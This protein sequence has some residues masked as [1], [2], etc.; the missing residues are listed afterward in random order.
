MA[1]IY[2]HIPFCRKAC[3]YCNFHFSTS[4]HRK[5]AL[6]KALETE[7]SRAQFPFGVV[8]E[9]I[10][11]TVYF[12]GG[13]PSLLSA[14]ELQAILGAM[15]R[16]FTL[17]DA[18]EI[19]LEAN[20][21]DITTAKLADWK[22]AGIN[23][24][25][26]GVQSFFEDDLLW[27]NRA[28]TASQAKACIELA[29]KS[30]F[31][32]LTIDLIYGTPTLDDDRWRANVEQAIALGVNHL[33]CYALTVEENTALNHF[34]KKGRIPPVNEERQERQF[35][36]LMDWM[37]AAGF[38]H[39]EIS[40]FARPG[41]RSKHNSN[42]WSGDAY[43]GF[44]PS[45]HSFDGKDT[46]WWNVANNTLYIGRLNRD[47]EA[48]FEFEKLSAKQQ[49]NEYIMTSLRTSEGLNY[50]TGA[51]TINDLPVKESAFQLFEQ[52]VSGYEQ[53]GLLWRELGQVKLTR[54]GK[55]LADGIAAR[56]FLD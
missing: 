16:R 28:H 43:Y 24:L 46:R 19:T 3:H 42:Y 39:Y 27:M 12:G 10:I 22:S 18:T 25:S 45:A 51:Q 6:L 2:V 55:M 29:L 17:T 23:R 26:I 50:D 5:P 52:R 34:I 41:H 31:E 1:G 53:Q 4:L 15:K 33:S 21:D 54:Q 49:V 48:L 40:N 56:L 47:D 35:L 7:I 8:P 14:P 9:R 36:L 37:E 11:N 38:E 32:N 30:G 20:P 44:G 13:T